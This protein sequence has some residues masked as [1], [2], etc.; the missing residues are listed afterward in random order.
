MKSCAT[1]L[2]REWLQ[3]KIGWTVAVAAPLV[4]SLLLLGVS[5]FHMT[6]NDTESDVQFRQLPA[7]VLALGAMIGVALLTFA[8]AWV[9]SLIQA[10]GLARR[11]QQDRSIEFWLSLP[12]GHTSSVAAPLLAHLLL[13]P[14]AALLV[15][16]LGGQLIALLLVTKFSGIGAWFGLPWVA[17]LLVVLTVTVR[18]LLGLVL[19][20]LW[21]SPLI[22][23]AMVASAWLKR[24]GL[25]ALIG[26]VVV[27]GNVLAKAYGNPIVWDVLDG[28]LARAGQAL[29]HAREPAGLGL[30]PDGDPAAALAGLP[31]WVWHDAGQSLAALGDPW[32]LFVVLA[33]AGGFALLI[34]RRQRGA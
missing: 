14:A 13:F 22:L 31:A 15:G 17:L 18:L 2:Q 4:L 30:R 21:L 10:P 9:S 27:L 29:I 8:G 6:V 34:L 19:A 25:P 24:W 7:L 28:L 5:Q 26:A 16:V 20:T 32:L 23:L 11:D 12:I 3:H 33:S 1:L